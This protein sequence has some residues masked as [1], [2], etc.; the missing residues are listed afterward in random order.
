M[1]AFVPLS[2]SERDVV[3]CVEEEES[4]RLEHQISNCL[5]RSGSGKSQSMCL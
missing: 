4:A 2:L 1:V 3:G 5:A